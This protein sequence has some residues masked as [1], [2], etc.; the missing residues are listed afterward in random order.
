MAA[1]AATAAMPKAAPH[2][3][4]SQDLEGLVEMEAFSAASLANP[5]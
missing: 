2:A 4:V 3:L 1:T 5:A